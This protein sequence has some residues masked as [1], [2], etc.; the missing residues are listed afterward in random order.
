MCGQVREWHSMEISALGVKFGS[1]E[2]E[3]I[4]KPIAPDEVASGKGADGGGR[5]L[6][7]HPPAPKNRSTR[8]VQAD[9]RG[10][11]KRT[12]TVREG[13]QE[14][15]KKPTSCFKSNRKRDLMTGLSSDL[16]KML[17]LE[18]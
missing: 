15:K 10:P 11:A 13:D 1:Y 7:S 8:S 4:L 14:S 16:C 3:M 17:L 9:D 2:P 6:E 18:G 12:E 5:E